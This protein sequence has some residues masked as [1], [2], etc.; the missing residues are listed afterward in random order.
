MYIPSYH[1]HNVLNVYSRQLAQNKNSARP[2]RDTTPAAT[3]DTI[4]ISA[5]ARRQSVIEKVT[6]EIIDRITQFGPQEEIDHEIVNKLKDELESQ[7][8]P[9]ESER[10]PGN[11]SSDFVF[12]QID[13]ADNKTTNSLAID[14][15]TLFLNRLEEV[16]KQTMDKK[17]SG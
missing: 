17:M 7:G 10:T 15:S 1:M 2:S 13:G 5:E 6:G 9:M 3:Q 16:T 11:N 14:A 8:R 12:N 4:S